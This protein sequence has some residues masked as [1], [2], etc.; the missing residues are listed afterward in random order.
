MK[1][2]FF[3]LIFIVFIFFRVYS[4]VIPT[5][6]SET[7]K[8]GEFRFSDKCSI[9]TNAKDKSILEYV[10][11]VFCEN[12]G[13]SIQVSKKEPKHGIILKIEPIEFDSGNESYVIDISME[14]ITIKANSNNGLFYGVQTLWQLLPPNFFSGA[15]SDIN[16]LAVG[17]LRIEDKPKYAWRSFL[18][19]SGRQY[20]SVDFIKRY[21]D[22]LALFKINVFHWHLTE[23]DGW[24]IEIEKY[25]KLTQIGAYVANLPGQQGFY[26]KEDIKQVIIYAKSR[27]IEIMPEIDVP[28]HSD[29]ALKSYPE[30]TCN[31][32]T[33]YPIE[34]LE[35]SPH[36]YCGG[37]EDTYYFLE[38]VL[39]EVC[40]MFPFKYIH[41]GGDE[42]PKNIWDTCN[43]CA[44]K[45]KDEQLKGTGELQ[46][47]FSKRLAEYVLKKGK[48]PVFWEEAFLSGDLVLPQESVMHWWSY[49]RRGTMGYDYA[50]KNNYRVINSTNYY[51]YLCFPEKPWRGFFENRTFSFEDAYLKNPSHLSN[52]HAL[53][54]GM[55][56]S[57]WSDYNLVQDMVDIRVFPRLF[58][59]VEQMWNSKELADLE[60]FVSSAKEK[61]KLLDAL[62]VEYNPIYIE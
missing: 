56:T 43:V 54:L 36:L 35:H 20:H 46:Q 40:E 18:L 30:L 61:F 5:P 19:D 45:I 33:P 49:R 58:V 25:P 29:A 51:T 13:K 1:R 34:D 22:L 16:N 62:G 23:N 7:L 55:S 21:I 14:N 28:G 2:I 26:S 39:D 27:Y 10:N 4:S 31:K 32:C 53:V 52:P 9:F 3:L 47:Y 17:C 60:V 24:R 37:S 41:L 12:I 6:F 57:M 42:A 11:H 50:I 8:S 44:K 48:Y 38:N 15:I 59:M